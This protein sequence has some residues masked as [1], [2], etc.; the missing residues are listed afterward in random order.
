MNENELLVNETQQVP[1]VEPQESITENT[2]SEAVTVETTVADGASK[3]KNKK[4]LIIGLIAGVLSLCILFVGIISAIIVIGVTNSVDSIDATEY[5]VT[6]YVDDVYKIDYV[7]LPQEKADKKVKWEVI[8]AGI[9]SVDENGNVKA[10]AEGK[11]QV[12]L[13]VGNKT[14]VVDIIVKSGPDFQKIF[15]EF[16]ESEY[17]TV[18]SDGS[19]LTIDTNPDNID[20]YTNYSA[21]FAIG[22][23]NE[24]L[25]L[26]EA[27]MEK[28]NKTRAL[29]G[30]REEEFD[31]VRVTW[32]YHPD[33]GLSVTYE[34]VN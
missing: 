12:V 21:Y 3:K 13:S 9:V 26:P 31:E 23:V 33:N 1:E 25:G 17:A 8:P 19:Y 22:D 16:C 18:A 6:L 10:L 30:T 5:E 29:D 34:P 24:A 28:M 27:L 4:P 14:D 32:Q 20:D 15:D 11:A 2:L 7:I